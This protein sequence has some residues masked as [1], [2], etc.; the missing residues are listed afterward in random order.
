M[1]TIF[2]KRERKMFVVCPKCMSK[3]RIPLEITLKEGQKLQCSSCRCV[4]NFQPEKN[5]NKNESSVSGIQIPKDPVLTQAVVHEE[6][7]VYTR[8]LPEVFT[9]L[10]PM[11]KRSSYTWIWLIICLGIFFVSVSGIWFYRDMLKIDY[12]AHSFPRLSKKHSDNVSNDLIDIPLFDEETLPAKAPANSDAACTDIFA[13][14]SIRFRLQDSSLLIEGTVKN[15]TEFTQS[16]PAS[17][18]VTAYNI[19]GQPIFQKE[20]FLPNEVLPPYGQKAFFGSYSPAPD[21]VQWIE[22]SCKK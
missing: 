14:H 10:E 11:A 6:K 12:S 17:V 1:Y 13:F 5:E 22:A 19:H 9:P 18:Y 2:G 4:F 8:K 16:V 3:Y 15:R 7:I 21:G 20:I